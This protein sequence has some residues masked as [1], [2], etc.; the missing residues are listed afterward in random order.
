MPNNKW[1]NCLPLFMNF[2]KLFNNAFLS[3]VKFEFP[4]GEILH[5]HR[6]ILSLNSE[7]FYEQCSKE[8]N[9][10][11]VIKIDNYSFNAFSN[12]IK[13]LYT[14]HLSS[15]CKNIID[16][17]LKLCLQYGTN[18][19]KKKIYQCFFLLF[20]DQNIL[21]FYEI[22]RQENLNKHL[23]HYE[24]IIVSHFEKVLK[25]ES[26]LEINENTLSAVLKLDLVSDVSEVDIFAAVLKWSERACEKD[27]ITSD[28][29]N[30]RQKLG[31]NLKLIRFGAMTTEEFGKCVEME[32][33]LFSKKEII[34]LFSSIANKTENS[35]GFSC[36]KK[37]TIVKKN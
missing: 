37:R 28:S 32:P 9:D 10:N 6:F 7:V 11:T 4:N 1:V 19:L 21:K 3:D 12:F 27:E 5:A 29:C 31:D 13:L 22:I 24:N 15:S 35:F 17:V 20:D 23:I 33:E 16:D 8:C 30:K 14:S 26:F 18:D 2:E 25:S 36:S 34:S